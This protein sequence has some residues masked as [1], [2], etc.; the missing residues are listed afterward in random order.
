MLSS[1]AWWMQNLCKHW[2]MMGTVS[3]K[4][5]AIQLFRH[6]HFIGSLG[7]NVIPDPHTKKPIKIIPSFEYRVINVA[8]TNQ[9]PSHF[10]CSLHATIHMQVALSPFGSQ[11]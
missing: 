1:V 6:I 3:A 11:G 4:C 2:Q 7:V 9:L 8:V 10:S 5:N